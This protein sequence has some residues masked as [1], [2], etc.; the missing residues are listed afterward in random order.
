MYFNLKNKSESLFFSYYTWNFQNY[1]Q[2]S[3]T[4]CK[5]SQITQYPHKSLI[6]MFM[7]NFTALCI[8]GFLI[9]FQL[10]T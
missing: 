9:I 5:N 6:K 7:Y 3:N 1:L 2:V 4:K 8:V 10:I